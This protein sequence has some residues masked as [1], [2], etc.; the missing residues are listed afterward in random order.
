MLHTAYHNVVAF[1]GTIVTLTSVMVVAVR[2]NC[3]SIVDALVQVK[4]W[5][6]AKVRAAAGKSSNKMVVD[7][8]PA[9]A[10]SVQAEITVPTPVARKRYSCP[11]SNWP[12]V[13]SAA[14]KLRMCDV[15]N[16]G[17]RASFTSTGTVPNGVAAAMLAP[18]ECISAMTCKLPS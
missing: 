3:T 11:V 7:V 1:N 15:L 5:A 17:K 18:P 9:N 4:V 8:Q 16:C 12:M 10:V 13:L 6:Q 2:F 14:V